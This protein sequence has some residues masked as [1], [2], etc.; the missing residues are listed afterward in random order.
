MTEQ[1]HLMK[2]ISLHEYIHV[3]KIYLEN[4]LSSFNYSKALLYTDS[5]QK[6]KFHNRL[7]N[8]RAIKKVERKL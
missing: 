6:I 1:L 7:N 8:M 5:D 4:V 3:E 2:K